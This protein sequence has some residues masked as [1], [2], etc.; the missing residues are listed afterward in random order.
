MIFRAVPQICSLLALEIFVRVWK[1]FRREI[2]IQSDSLFDIVQYL[3]LIGGRE[4][5]IFNSQISLEAVQACQWANP[6]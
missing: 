4:R 6:L 3:L 2:W 1:S 5:I